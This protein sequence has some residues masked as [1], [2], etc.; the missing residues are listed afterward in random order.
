MLWHITVKCSD[1]FWKL[2]LWCSHQRDKNSKIPERWKLSHC[3]EPSLIL[4]V[5]WE[6]YVYFNIFWNSP[7]RKDLLIMSIRK[8]RC[9][10]ILGFSI[11]IGISPYIVVLELSKLIIS[12]RTSSLVTSLKIEPSL[13]WELV[14]IRFE[15]GFPLKLP[16]R[17][18]KFSKDLHE[19]S[20]PFSPRSDVIFIKTLLNAFL[21]FFHLKLDY[22]FPQ[23]EVY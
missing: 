14:L 5:D 15:L 9:I 6:V 22:L 20:Q 2:S 16:R 3:W 11:A 7:S 13:V 12:W 19:D 23:G 8:S 1:N 17:F 18:P 10:F 21:E 4:F